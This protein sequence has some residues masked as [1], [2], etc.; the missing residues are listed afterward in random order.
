M[1]V[2]RNAVPRGLGLIYLGVLAALF[3]LVVNALNCTNLHTAR[4]EAAKPFVGHDDQITGPPL[5][6][7]IRGMGGSVEDT[8]EQ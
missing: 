5:E 2:P 8:I 1:N 4:N 7:A 6:K 3:F